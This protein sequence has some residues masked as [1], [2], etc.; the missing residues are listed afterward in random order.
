MSESL[1]NLLQEISQGRD[2]MGTYHRKFNDGPQGIQFAELVAQTTSGTEYYTN[3]T[4]VS[5]RFFQNVDY[6]ADAATGIDGPETGE[7][8]YESC[9]HW[10]TFVLPQK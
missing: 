10:H 1:M 3:E 7:H 4:A 9:G 2:E 5:E 6:T 8:G